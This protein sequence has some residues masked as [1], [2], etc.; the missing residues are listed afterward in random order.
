MSALHPIQ[1]GETLSQLANRYQ[2]SVQALAKANNIQNPDLIIAG[3]SLRIPDGFD[4]KPRRVGQMDTSKPKGSRPEEDGATPGATARGGIKAGKGWGG[5][6]GVADAGKAIARTL[7]I[8]VTSEKRNAQQTQ[9][10][11]SSTRS[12]HYTGNTNAYAVDFG[13]RGAKGDQL[14]RQLAQKYG[15]P[16]SNIGTFNKHTIEVDGKK[17]SVQLLWKVPDH[18]DHVHLGIRRVG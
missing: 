6:E 2:T 5:S 12:D 14:A 1:R 16:E 18:Y 7:G 10:A 17:Y 4:D 11:G 13:V 3:K 9:S 15:I 8:P